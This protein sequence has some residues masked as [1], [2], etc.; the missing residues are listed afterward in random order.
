[1]SHIVGQIFRPES[2]TILSHLQREPPGAAT[3][4]H[5]HQAIFD[6]EFT[7]DALLL[8]YLYVNKPVATIINAQ[9]GK[10]RSSGA[11]ASYDQITRS[12]HARTASLRAFS[13]T[14]PS[15]SRNLSG[16]ATA[17]AISG[18][19]ESTDLLNL[20]QIMAAVLTSAPTSTSARCKRIP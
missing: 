1:M 4:T 7:I 19:A 17:L 3:A 10:Y 8:V 18:I 13:A 2:M 11:S 14:D 9:N 20:S 6:Y 5:S 15:T 16:V 12:V